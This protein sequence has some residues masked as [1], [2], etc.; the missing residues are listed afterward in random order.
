[1]L[2]STHKNSYVVGINDE[3]IDNIKRKEEL[4]FYERIGFSTHI[5]DGNHDIDGPTLNHILK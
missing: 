2:T 1:M 3:F 5:Y 4:K